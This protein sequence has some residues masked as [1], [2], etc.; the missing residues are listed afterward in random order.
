MKKEM[1]TQCLDLLIDLI[2]YQPKKPR[3]MAKLLGK[4]IERYEEQGLDVP[5]NYY[6][7]YH[8]LMD[9]YDPNWRDD[10]LLYEHAEKPK[11]K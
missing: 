2:E 4:A 3:D 10:G 1:C 6:T 8:S 7:T 9:R 5:L 11:E